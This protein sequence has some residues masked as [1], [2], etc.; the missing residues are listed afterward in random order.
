M[1]SFPALW[2]PHIAVVAAEGPALEDLAETFPA[3]LFALASAY[4]TAEQRRHARQLLLAGAPLKAA[5]DVLELPFWLRRLPPSAFEHALPPMPMDPE[6]G[7]RIGSFLP[8]QGTDARL[9]LKTFCCALRAA[10]P[11][12][13]LWF[14]KWLKP[15]F[16]SE[17]SLQMMAAWAW[18]SQHPG[19]EGHALLRKGWSPDM[20]ARRALEEFNVWRRRLRLVDALGVGIAE[21]WL[22]D[23]AVA[24][25][26]F[27]QLRTVADFLIESERM[28]NCLDQYADQLRTTGNLVFSVRRGERRIACAEIGVH[29]AECTMPAIVQ[30]RGPRNRRASAEVWQATFAWLGA[31]KLTARKVRSP[32]MQSAQKTLARRQLWAPYLDHLE[33]SG[34]EEP[35]RRLLMLPNRRDRKS[36][37]Q[38]DS[39]NAARPGCARSKRR[40]RQPEPNFPCIGGKRTVP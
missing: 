37:G 11:A 21:T 3:L 28:E 4:G 17:E 35:L 5:A 13:A 16:M 1:Q 20:G 32:R 27:V 25:I 18:F 29:N 24:G 19:T 33:G 23:G 12:Y 22:H 34:L 15:A 8:R 26:S 36:V 7:L 9:W 38:A 14:A 39:K 40:K 2:Q 31:Q 6:F 30:L 10:G